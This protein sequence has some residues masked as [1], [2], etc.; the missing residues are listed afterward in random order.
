MNEKSPYLRY[1]FRKYGEIPFSPK[2]SLFCPAGFWKLRK[3]NKRFRMFFMFSDHFLHPDHVI[4]S[5][6]FVSALVE[7]PY[8]PVSHVGMKL[9]TVLRQIFIFRLRIADTGIQV[10]D[11]LCPGNFFHRLIQRPS[12]SCFRTCSF[13]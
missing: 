11:V 5:S 4:P 8:Q 6:E 3:W 1:S 2:I 13:T 12:D 10:R 7:F 9:R